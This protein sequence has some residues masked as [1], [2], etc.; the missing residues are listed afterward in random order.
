MKWAANLSLLFSEVPLLERFQA[1]KD[2]GFDA[3]EIQFP[4][5]ESLAKLIAAKEQANVE[6]VLINV[7]AGDLMQGGL[8]L[9]CVPDRQTQF[10]R[11]LDECLIYAEGLQVSCVN[12]LSGR[13]EDHQALEHY[14]KTFEA[15]LSKAADALQKINVLTSFEAINTIDMPNFLIHSAD[16]LWDIL[17]RL[18][19]SNL[20]AQYDLYHMAMMDE[21]LERDLT[22]Y[23]DKIG[24]IQFADCPGRN[25]PGTGKLDFQTLFSII[26]QS[27]YAGSIGAEYRPRKKTN[28]TLEWMNHERI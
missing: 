8:G 22:H 2:A 5:E 18:K 3:V 17:D 10:A 15:N 28:E 6:I 11:A 13:C 23:A 1:A 16:H 20:K 4:Y 14:Q 7:P 9:A 12:V 19:H 21:N 25:E 27:A 24:H 26:Q